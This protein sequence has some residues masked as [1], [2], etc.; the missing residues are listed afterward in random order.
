MF[1]RV[2]FGE[3]RSAATL[4]PAQLSVEQMMYRATLQVRRDAENEIAESLDRIVRRDV[5]AGM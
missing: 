5:I 2:T 4:T 3:L 1:T